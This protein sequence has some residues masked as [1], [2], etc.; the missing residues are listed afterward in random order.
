M[1]DGHG[2]RHAQGLWMAFLEHGLM[3]GAA[4][5]A[6]ILELGLVDDDVLVER[7]ADQPDHQAR[8]KR[9]R[10]AR[11]IGDGADSDAGFLLHFPAGRLLDRLAGLHEAGQRR[12][13]ALGP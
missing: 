11:D 13:H 9:P 10:L 7:L 3:L 2:R 12:I 5:P 6:R 8:G 4:E 1:G